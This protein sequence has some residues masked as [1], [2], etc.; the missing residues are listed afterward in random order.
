M[1]AHETIPGTTGEV[2]VL[3]S[4]I[5]S[6]FHLVRSC[7]DIGRYYCL[8]ARASLAK[9]CQ[10]EKCLNPTPTEGALK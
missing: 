1:K 9:S 8:S 2:R 4:A 7:G 10:S 5:Y 6:Q 3:L